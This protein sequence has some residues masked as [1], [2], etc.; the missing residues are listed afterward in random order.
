M[1]VWYTCSQC[2]ALHIGGHTCA[3]TSGT[4]PLFGDQVYPYDSPDADT[5]G[6]RGV[7]CGPVTLDNAHE[8]K[9]H[10]YKADKANCVLLAEV[11]RLRVRVKELEAEVELQKQVRGM[12]K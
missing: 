3:A 8:W 5:C 10:Y 7:A 12:G 2:R 9:A 1:P 4:G 6:R 11:E